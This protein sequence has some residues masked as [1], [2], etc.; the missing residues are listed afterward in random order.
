MKIGEQIQ[1]QRK[2]RGISQA[3]LAQNLKISPQSISKWENGET[4]PSFSNVVAISEMFDISLDQLIKED[5]EL[6]NQLEVKNSKISKTWVIVIVGFIVAIIMIISMHLL[7]VSDDNI[8]NL[9][10]LPQLIA[11][12][13]ILF[14][15]NWKKFNQGINKRLLIWGIVWLALYLIPLINDFVAGFIAGFSGH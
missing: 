5:T 11:F 2:L 7:K 9:L 1:I 4:L 13:F 15:I 12:S 8:D 10:V 3:E 14:N 6:M